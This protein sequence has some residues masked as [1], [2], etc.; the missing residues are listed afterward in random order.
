MIQSV[1]DLINPEITAQELELLKQHNEQQSQI[2]CCPECGCR[3]IVKNGKYERKPRFIN[4]HNE[5]VCH[6]VKVQKYLCKG[7]KKPFN[8]IPLFLTNRLRY[9]ILAILMVVLQGESKRAISKKFDIARS[10]IKAFQENTVSDINRLMA[11]V[12]KWKPD[13]LKLLLE[14]FKMM[15]SRTLLSPSTS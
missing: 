14:K 7:C 12:E 1:Q 5:V 3:H 2:S 15:F 8:D 10:T 13:N 9:S 4:E 6:K 11:V